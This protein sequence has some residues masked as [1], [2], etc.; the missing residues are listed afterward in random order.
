MKFSLTFI[1][2]L[3][4]FFVNAQRTVLYEIKNIPVRYGIVY[5]YSHS[6]TGCYSSGIEI[7]SNGDSVFSAS[8]GT[9]T[10]VGKIES[11][12]L[13]IIKDK[14]SIFHIYSHIKET[15]LQKGEKINEGV[16]LGRL[17]PSEDDHGKF[18]LLF[19]L[20][21]KKGSYFD[22]NKIFELLKENQQQNCSPKPQEIVAL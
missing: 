3:E 2:C 21:D 18:T 10:Y 22:N 9:I 16:F 6:L 17:L 15:N 12:F 20:S 5:Q 8:K 13:I 4:A 1:V 19:V 11:G 14:K 7:S